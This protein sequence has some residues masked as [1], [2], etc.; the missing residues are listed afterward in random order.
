MRARKTLVQQQR[1]DGAGTANPFKYSLE[2]RR[3]FWGAP[4]FSRGR[5]VVFLSLPLYQSVR[6]FQWTN[7]SRHIASSSPFFFDTVSK[8]LMAMSCFY[9]R[10]LLWTCIK[11]RKDRPLPHGGPTFPEAARPTLATAG[12]F[13]LALHL[14]SG[15]EFFAPP[16]TTRPACLFAVFSCLPN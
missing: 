13:F 10:D 1:L 11:G 6:D 16:T 7:S 3:G 8:H 15:L 2:G 4:G 9:Y 5:L 14:Y 12:A